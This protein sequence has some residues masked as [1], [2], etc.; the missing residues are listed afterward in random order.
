MD[1]TASMLLPIPSENFEI[2][3]SKRDWVITVGIAA[4]YLISAIYHGDI[5]FAM[6]PLLYPENPR[7]RHPWGC[8]K[9]QTREHQ[10]ASRACPQGHRYLDTGLA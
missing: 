4:L 9:R 10:R 6:T 3:E 8:R 1:P 5:H 7:N 2:P